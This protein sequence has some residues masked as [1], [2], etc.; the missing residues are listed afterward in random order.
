MAGATQARAQPTL[1]VLAKI[2][3]WP[4]VSKLI[5]YQGRIW[6]ANSVKGRN[7]NSA[8]LYSYDPATGTLRYEHHL[9]S[10]DAG[11]PLVADGLL[12]WPYEDGRFSLGLGHYDVT[13]GRTWESGTIYGARSFHTHAMAALDGRLIAATSAWRGKLQSSG[14]GGRHWR[15]DYD[16]PTPEGRVTRFV[17]LVSVNGMI[18]GNLVSRDG[19]G[20]RRLDT[21]E[22]QA[23]PGWPENRALVAVTSSA[24]TLYGLVREADGT[25]LWRSDGISSVQLYGP[26]DNWPAQDIAAATD[27]LWV[28]T[29]EGDGSVIW[30]STDGQAWRAVW[31]LDGGQPQEILVHK[32]QVYAAGRGGT[33]GRGILWG[34]APTAASTP[35]VLQTPPP[36]KT[37]PRPNSRDWE[38][39][40]AELD[41]LLGEP[42]TF[43][44][45]GRK[46]RGMLF[47]LVRESPPPGFFADRL[48]ALMP[49][50][51]V[52]LIGGA[53]RVEA[54]TLGRWLL[55]WA[56]AAAGQGPVPPNLIAAPWTAPEN[57]SEKYF[58]T[59]PIAIWTAGSLGQDD[60][61]TIDAL[62]ERLDR[63]GDPDWLAGDVIGALTAITDQRFGYDVAAWRDWW[64]G[65]AATWT[66]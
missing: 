31:R 47:A 42:E 12:Y 26:D 24:T 22:A 39:A 32:G 34:P 9:F 14:D 17:D 51:P 41:R 4:V 15:L 57:P 40:G 54:R 60:R 13:D 7:H 63:P 50:D 49:G 37:P 58:E 33:D 62:I 11:D 20:L 21:G 25:A 45:H 56:M 3:P 48:D 18:F 64:A 55:L 44:N 59:A 5:A 1:P 2:G 52:S 53:V 10:Q 29:A 65:V 28:M 66:H 43:A 35:N 38:A 19:Q 23:P 27:G 30:H 6:L 61:A 46:L 36:L 8:D 16:H